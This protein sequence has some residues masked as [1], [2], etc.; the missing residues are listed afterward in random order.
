MTDTD[1]TIHN[2][3][4]MTARRVGFGDTPAVVVVDLQTGLT[5]PEYSLGAD[6]GDV[7]KETN[8]V[9]GAANDADVPVFY[10][11]HVPYPDG[12]RVGI[13]QKIE[14]IDILDPSQ[15]SGR[16]D[17]RLDVHESSTVVD[18][19]QASAFH[20]TT[21]NSTL[22]SMGF[23]TVIV[24]GC[25]TSGCIRATT[26]DACSHGYR[27]I[28]PELC[29]GDRSAEQHDANLQDIHVRIGDVV[30]TEEVLEYLQSKVEPAAAD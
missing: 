22:T 30:S 11:R 27:T 17:D 14:D 7:I 3:V 28:V 12:R 26:L 20:E 15:K 6:L 16:L 18:K 25:S 9:T 24:A 19:R 4:G 10:T 1:E 13:W 29:V 5:R 2:R 8:R 21:L 23:D